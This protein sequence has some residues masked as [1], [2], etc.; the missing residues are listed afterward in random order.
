MAAIFRNEFLMTKI[1]VY[2]DKYW[3]S[4]S[5]LLLCTRLP[6]GGQ[7]KILSSDK[8]NIVILN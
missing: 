2:N 4:V 7:K 8:T 3:I 1:S 6:F 5:S